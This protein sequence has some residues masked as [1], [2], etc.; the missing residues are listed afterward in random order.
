MVSGL[1][2]RDR[3]P[4]WDLE[5][6]RTV[7]VTRQR[8]HQQV[9]CQDRPSSPPLIY[10]VQRMINFCSRECQARVLAEDCDR[11]TWR[12]SRPLL[13][14]WGLPGLSILSTLL[15]SW[16]HSLSPI[17][18]CPLGL[19]VWWHHVKISRFLERLG[20]PQ[21]CAEALWEGFLFQV[22]FLATSRW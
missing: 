11:S 17:P 21:W 7:W 9:A 3:G 16:G 14:L 8:A 6:G 19:W 13:R 5:A 18:G 10:L 20:S 1:D 15:S 4:L 2:H 22:H 12:A